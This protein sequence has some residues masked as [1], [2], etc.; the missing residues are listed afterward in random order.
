M[1][2]ILLFGWLGVILLKIVGV[3]VVDKLEWKYIILA[4]V[5]YAL[6]QLFMFFF[7]YVIALALLLGG[8]YLVC[9]LGT[10]LLK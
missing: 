5:F 10:H 4:P 1:V 7:R 9:V 2:Q 8:V 3:P 6:I